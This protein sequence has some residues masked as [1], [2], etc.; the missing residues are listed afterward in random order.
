ME[1]K[2]GLYE[3]VINKTI[4]EKIERF[5]E[6]K[7]IQKNDIDNAESSIVLAQYI[8]GV[9]RKALNIVEGDSDNRIYKQIDICNKIIKCLNEEIKDSSIEEYMISKDAEMLL[10]VLDKINTSYIASGD[11][12]IVR[13]STSLSQSSL[14]TGSNAEPSLVTELKKEIMSSDSI[15]M[16][17]SFIKW[18]GLRM[19]ADELEIFTKEHQLRI[20]TT[21]YMGATDYKAIEFLSNLPN[22]DVKISYDTKRTRLHAKAYLF[23][24]ETGFSTAYIGSSNLSNAAITSG[25]EWNIKISEQDSRDIMKKFIATFEAYW[26]DKEFS[27]F[28]LSQ[29]E[30][31]KSALIAEKSS[32]DEY[33]AFSF[34][35]EPYPYQKEILDNLKAEREIHGRYRNL[36]VAATGVGKT[37]IS[38][39][40]YKR[41][42]MENP[43]KN[44][45][46]LFIAHRQE[47]LKQSL[48]CFRGIL[49]DQNFGDLWVGNFN[50]QQIDHLFMSIQTFNSKKF[51]K[52]TS[53]DFYDFIIIDEFHHTAAP[54][55]QKLLQYYKPKILLGLTATPER[56]DGK[57]VLK[58]F[59]GRIAS[60]MRLYEAIDRKLLSP[61]QYFGVSDNVDLSHLTWSRGG[62]DK[63]ELENVY[64]RNTQRS[65]LVIKSLKKCV[66][67][68]NDV[69]GLGFCV[70]VE[71][72]N[73]MANFFNS[74][75]ISSIAL[76]SDSSDE[77]RQTAKERLIKKEI[78]FIF[79]VD[80]YNEG[81]DIPEVNTILFLR[82]T[83]S[84]TV[85]LQQLGRGLRLCDG[86]D[87]LTVLDFVGQAHKKY[88]FEDKLRALMGK[89]HHTVQREIENQ[90]PN[91]PKGCFIQLE[92]M[93]QKYILDNIKSSLNNKQNI[94][95][96]I[97]TFV[98]DTGLKLNLGNFISHYNM[99][100]NDIYSKACWNRLCVAAGV[101]ENF[102]NPDEEKLTKAIN[103]LSHINSR[104]WIEF[105]LYQLEN[106]EQLNQSLLNDEQ[107]KMLLMFHYTIWQEPLNKL[108]FGS[109]RD[110]LLR[111][112]N[113]KEMFE[114]IKEVLKVNY[115]R[116]DFVDSKIDLEFPCPLDLHCEYSRDEVLSALGYYTEYKKPSQREGVVYIPDKKVDVFFITL[117]KSEKDYSPS[118]L[119]DD[120]SIDETLFHWQSQS[121]TSDTSE[122][123]RRYINHKSMG[124]KVLLFVREY[125]KIEGIAS[126]YCYLGTANFVSYKE[127]RPMNIIWKLDNAVPA[128]LIKKSN[129][130]II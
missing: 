127:S 2:N 24:R 117:N 49:K 41:F 123:G 65:N 28:D 69:V 15:D 91:L 48:S 45:R 31:L 124:S 128:F 32:K 90:F 68:I 93:A 55:Y 116:I 81:V 10:A 130:M 75:G 104:R 12:R 121:T 120:Y 119:Y 46:L 108:G 99:R 102:Y 72:A 59:D 37:V 23:H 52:F 57:N 85:F 79:V 98:Q 92:K 42:C 80:L 66:T 129:K 17:M 19:I 20:I 54:T 25:L 126:P 27:H 9:V 4:L 18:S 47:I 101:R 13:P 22:T 11:K 76:H 64:T 88:R 83:E 53:P 73:Y 95:N 60:E 14:F 74:K 39:F 114:E 29:S 67:D 97:E 5:G 100:I 122:T 33:N 78:H 44:N 3:Q 111:I 70:S 87:Y 84:L 89:T 118:T 106:I 103:R 50:P 34:D 86:K 125:K 105:L 62:Y 112:Y 6:N 21:S 109:I 94:I 16:L 7:I 107:R 26:H 36:V 40:D 63:T 51:E 82:P 110:S 8:S 58:Y 35:I 56:M 1:L 96:K 38:A 113:N 115:Q 30:A 61:F 43:N 71:H 77:D